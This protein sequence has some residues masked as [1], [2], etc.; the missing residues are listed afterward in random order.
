[1]NP[2]A[3]MIALIPGLLALAGLFV[4]GWWAWTTPAF[5]FG[6]VPLADQL[7]K[8]RGPDVTARSWHQPVA[9]IL[10]F[11]C[12]SLSLGAFA[13]LLIKAGL[14]F[15]S[16]WSWAGNV[17][18]VG[19]L[20]G[21]YA[22]NV[23]HELGHRRSRLA[24]MVAQVLMA[25]TLYGHF[26]IEHNLGHHVRVA[27]PDDP[28]SARKGE[29][30]FAFW[31]R[32]ILG[33]VRSAYRLAS[34]RV[35]L[36]WG[37]QVIGIALVSVVSPIAAATW[38]VAAVVG[39]LLLET[40]NYLEHYGLSRARLPDGRYERVQPKH[41]WNAEHVAGRAVLFD[42]PRHADHHANPRRACT[43]LREFKEA[44]QLPLGYPAMILIA[45]LP[46]LF[47]RLMDDALRRANATTLAG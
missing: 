8:Q 33:G 2:I 27:T 13:G 29:W 18:S 11:L 17:L 35:A 40:V 24:N 45:L 3:Y 22:L 42:L 41:S 12:V 30:V 44:P 28:A 37:A 15:E 43:T 1:M 14:G 10:M 46:P 31:I 32:S 6:V 20:F 19:T 34:R 9:D 26:W 39:I 21:V 4:E 5:V 38:I 7:G 23:G 25:S 16:G 36:T 47:M